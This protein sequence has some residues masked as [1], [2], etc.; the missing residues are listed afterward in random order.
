MGL[1]E[2]RLERHAR[3]Q[4]TKP[5]WPS[6]KKDR[7]KATAAESSERIRKNMVLLIEQVDLFFYLFALTVIYPLIMY[8]SE[9]HLA[10][11]RNDPHCVAVNAFSPIS[12]TNKGSLI[13]I[14]SQH[15]A[16]FQKSSHRTFWESFIIWARLVTVD[17]RDHGL[18]YWR[19]TLVY[20]LQE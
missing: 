9:V 3:T 19:E 13:F 12:N 18:L 11:S 5:A 16:G 4:G 8:R 17:V 20:A 1:S 7:A 6:E 15:L 2:A 10:V 14:Q